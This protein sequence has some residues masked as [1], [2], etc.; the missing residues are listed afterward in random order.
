MV[1]TF[2]QQSQI[3]SPW[4]DCVQAFFLRYP[5]PH[6]THVHTVDVLERRIEERPPRAGSDRP[7]H[8]LYTAR[9][10]LKRGSL[11]RWAPRGLIKS[12]ESWVLEESVVDL[13]ATAACAPAPSAP[14]LRTMSLWTRNLDHTNVL[15]VTEGI[16]FQEPAA[17]TAPDSPPPRT[18]CTTVA[19]IRSE[20]KFRLLQRRIEKFGLNRYISHKDTSRE[21]LLWSIHHLSYLR[22]PSAGRA[23]FAQASFPLTRT[24]RFLQALRPPF[25]DGV[26][27]S[28]LQWV[29]RR[30]AQWRAERRASTATQNGS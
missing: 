29:R 12:S 1:K 11:P 15:A 30:W 26:P 17:G 4:A 28:P 3:P 14:V 23:S 21:S 7:T 24:Q 16:R 2:A 20:I 27:A 5:N 18:T 13:D 10:M 8:V 22:S 25:L 6:A 19:D 9:L